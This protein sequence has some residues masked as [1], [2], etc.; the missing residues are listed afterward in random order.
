LTEDSFVSD[1]ACLQDQRLT[2]TS[3]GLHKKT[4]TKPTQNWKFSELQKK[5]PGESQ[6]NRKDKPDHPPEIGLNVDTD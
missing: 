6:G 3:S 1:L 4:Y 2:L 5:Q